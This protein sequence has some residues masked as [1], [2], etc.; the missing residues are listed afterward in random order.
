MSGGIFMRAKDIKKWLDQNSQH[1]INMM[2]LNEW[3]INICVI[4]KDN[5]Q[6]KENEETIKTRGFCAAGDCRALFQY[7]V[8]SIRLFAKHIKNEAF[9]KRVVVH[10]L[11]HV[12]TSSF[13]LFTRYFKNTGLYGNE[14]KIAAR[15]ERDVCEML[16]V[17]FENVICGNDENKNFIRNHLEYLGEDLDLC[18]LPL[19]ESE[20]N[21]ILE[22]DTLA[23][24]KAQVEARLALE[25]E[26]AEGIKF[27]NSQ[28]E[29]I[30]DS[31]QAKKPPLTKAQLEFAAAYK[32]LEKAR[33]K[34]DLALE[35]E[36]AEIES[37][38][39]Q[40]KIVLIRKK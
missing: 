7:R 11:A 20:R 4:S 34:V 5:I 22:G 19:K 6:E 23:V 16:A 12:A 8:A 39:S 29:I 10:E 36:R 28:K 32:T 30:L 18:Y 38:N 37:K 35:K 26:R 27:R 17:Q 33:E 21:I 3:H 13:F 40:N 1:Y 14:F 31:K 9:L 24:K 25:K 15:I 2:Y